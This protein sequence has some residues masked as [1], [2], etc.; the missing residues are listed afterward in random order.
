MRFSSLCEIIGAVHLSIYVSSPFEQRGGLMLVA[1][2]GHLKT[3]AAEIL[4]EFPC[5]LIISDL[6]VKSTI[7]LR[8]EFLGGNIHTLVFSDY[9][10]IYKRHQSVSANIEGIIMSLAGEGFRK[11]AFADQRVSSLP[12]RATF[13]GCVTNKFSEAM[14]EQWLDNGFHRRF[15]WAR[16]RVNN[17]EYLEEAIARWHKA[18]LDGSF[19]A[20]IPTSR[21]ISYTLKKDEVNK[22]QHDLR[23]TPDRKMSL[24]LAQK[25]LCVLKWKFARKDEKLPMKI[26]N[27]FAESLGRDGATVYL[28]DVVEEK[29]EKAVERVKK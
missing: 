26:W 19:S 2:P 29:K 24:I 14:E 20:R 27:D 25:I 8:D 15:M 11:P 7:A 3:T 10:K 21:N 18:E 9:Q 1:P 23:F 28:S 6:T 4:S 22:L 16:Y 12:A 13:V 5:T 17:P